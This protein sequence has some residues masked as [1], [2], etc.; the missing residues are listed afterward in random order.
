MGP[1]PRADRGV[2]NH[3]GKIPESAQPAV[4]PLLIEVFNRF[5]D[6]GLA[7]EDA[8]LSQSNAVSENIPCEERSPSRLVRDRL[9]RRRIVTN[10]PPFPERSIGCSTETLSG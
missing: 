6:L 9:F 7:E 2:L 10:G 8:F 1:D 5:I 4:R 3:Q